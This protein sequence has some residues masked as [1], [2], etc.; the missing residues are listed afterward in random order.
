MEK[1]LL[2]QLKEK[3]EN[4]KLSIE[5]ELGSF[6]TADTDQKD[7][8]NTRYPNRE[9]GNM[10][11]EADEMQEYDNML[12]VEHNLELRLKDINLAIE[13]IGNGSYGKCEKCGSEIEE[14]RLKANPEARLCMKCNK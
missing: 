14:E 3:L 10:E 12:S 9:M 5:K 13:K 6:A 7:N 4:E 8:W 1:N 2:E 11:E